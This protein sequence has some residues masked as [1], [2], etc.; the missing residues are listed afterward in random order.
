MTARV[1]PRY[2]VNADAGGRHRWWHV[3]E[4]R[5]H[6]ARWDERVSQRVGADVLGD[7]GAAGD[8]ADDPGG[9]VPVQPAPVPGEEQRPFSPLADGQVDRPRGAGRELDGDHLA[10]LA[11][12]DQGTVASLEAQMIDVGAGRLGYAQAAEGEQ[13]DQGV[14]GGRSEPGGDQEGRRARCGLGRWRSTRSPAAGGR[15]A[16]PGSG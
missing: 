2:A 12:D 16:R 13:G 1:L 5:W 9:A 15:R 8:P 6:R 7:P 10:A 4:T 11:R 3:R 14:L